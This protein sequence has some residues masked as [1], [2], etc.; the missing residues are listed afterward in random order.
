[1]GRPLPLLLIAA[2]LLV[3]AGCRDKDAGAPMVVVIG[4]KAPALADGDSIPTDAAAAVLRSATAQGLVRLDANAQIESGLAERWNVSDDG[5]SYIFRLQSG[6][7]PDG[8]PI[9]ARDVAR[10]LTRQLKAP[11]AGPVRDAGGAID[12]VVAM[13]DRVIEIRL[14]APRP[15]LLTLLA[16]PEFALIHEGTG[17]GPFTVESHDEDA[18]RLVHRAPGFD[19]EPGS[20]EE[21]RLSVLPAA[22]AIAAFKASHAALVLGGTVADLPL[23]RNAA[24]PR[25][26]LQFDP[27]AGLFGIMPAKKTAFTDSADVRVVLDQAIDRQAL[28]AALDVPNLGPRATLL[29]AGLNGIAAPVQPDWLAVPAADRRAT[30][31]A[32]LAPSL[33]KSKDGTLPKVTL[34]APEGPGGD[35]IV[36]RIALDWGALGLAVE[37]AKSEKGADFRFVD[38]VAPSDSA[39]WFVR[40]FRCDTAPVCDEEIDRLTEDARTTLLPEARAGL[41]ALA[42]QKVDGGALF[43]PIAAPI[44]WSLVSRTVPGFTTNRYARH[45]LLALTTA[46]GAA[47]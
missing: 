10:L 17:S 46:S 31:K 35:M 9:R 16:Q 24:L 20:S 18:M 7:W 42:A 37:R 11:N 33:P 45:S 14:K 25:G 15:N 29:E 47:R 43:M 8:K 39:A 12:E 38:E 13:T 3:V 36:A 26:T 1:M 41:L 19:G 32:R 28:I 2:S 4:D 23:A 30:L 40:R 34:W 6:E 21:V 27:A 5:L 44:R 22:K